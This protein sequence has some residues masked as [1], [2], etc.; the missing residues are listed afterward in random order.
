MCKLRDELIL[1]YEGD[2]VAVLQKD[3]SFEVARMD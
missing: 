2:W 1:V 3:G